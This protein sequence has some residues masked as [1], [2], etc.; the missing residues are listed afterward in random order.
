MKNR[1]QM[2]RNMMRFIIRKM[3]GMNKN[4]VKLIPVVGHRDLLED[5]QRMPLK[6]LDKTE[7]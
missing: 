4:L 6:D 3:M 1:N 5:Y 2:P 7:K